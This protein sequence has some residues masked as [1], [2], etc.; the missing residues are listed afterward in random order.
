MFFWQS[1]KTQQPQ[2]GNVVKTIQGVTSNPV[3]TKNG[4]TTTSSGDLARRNLSYSSLASTTSAASSTLQQH[5]DDSIS[6]VE[7]QCMFDGFY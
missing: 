1:T 3:L 5:H 7:F 6:S 4:D 2:Q